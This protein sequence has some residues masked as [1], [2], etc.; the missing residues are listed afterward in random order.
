MAA[1]TVDQ[2]R[3][4]GERATMDDALILF[5]C[6]P[7]RKTQRVEYIEFESVEERKD[8]EPWTGKDEP[9]FETVPPNPWQV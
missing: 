2:F 4:S 9:D 3:M 1:K 6:T 5:E 7:R 8:F